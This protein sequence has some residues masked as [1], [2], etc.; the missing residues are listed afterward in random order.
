M[1]GRPVPIG[2]LDTPPAE[3]AEAV[4]DRARKF[5]G[6]TLVLVLRDGDWLLGREFAKFVA[7]AECG[8]GR[9]V[10]EISRA[11]PEEQIARIVEGAR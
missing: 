9:V 2:T 6:K 10:A 1:S 3:V 11:T 4:L 8:K 7:D 5:P